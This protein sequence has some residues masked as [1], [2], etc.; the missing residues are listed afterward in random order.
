MTDDDRARERTIILANQP[1]TLTAAASL[2]A[3]RGPGR[4][5]IAPRKGSRQGELL[6]PSAPSRSP[7]RDRLPPFPRI[8]RR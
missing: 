4:S 2:G 1:G 7:D 5:G 8:A 6:P 3:I